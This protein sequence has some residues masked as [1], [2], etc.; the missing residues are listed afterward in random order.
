MDMDDIRDRLR[1]H[2]AGVPQRS[3]LAQLALDR[4]ESGMKD[5]E[6]LGHRFIFGDEGPAPTVLIFP[7]MLY[8]DGEPEVQVHSTD[9]LHDRLAD[10]WREHP[11]ED[12]ELGPRP[13]GHAEAVAKPPAVDATTSHPLAQSLAAPAAPGP[14]AHLDEAEAEIAAA[15]DDDKDD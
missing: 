13:N 1:E 10:G 12:I 8:R 11:S 9:E 7:K 14:L 6:A 3:M 2:H 4:I 15:E 5:L